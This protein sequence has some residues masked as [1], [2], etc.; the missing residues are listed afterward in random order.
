MCVAICESI[1]KCTSFE[2]CSEHANSFCGCWWLA[3]RKA[4]F[5]SPY[6]WHCFR[7]HFMQI[8]A[9]HYHSV[10]PTIC[11]PATIQFHKASSTGFEPW[12]SIIRKLVV[13]IQPVWQNQLPDDRPS[14]RETCRRYFV[15]LKC[16]RCVFGWLYT[17]LPVSQCTVSYQ[18]FQYPQLLSNNANSWGA[19]ASP[20]PS[21]QTAAVQETAESSD[22]SELCIAVNVLLGKYR[23][24]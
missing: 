9:G 24:S 11:T 15:K 16:S 19:H 21:V 23:Q 2:T 22:Y 3:A 17:V 13:K 4:N 5:R 14:P 10:Q 20:M 18:V 12:R 8:R 7:S 6:T 1:S